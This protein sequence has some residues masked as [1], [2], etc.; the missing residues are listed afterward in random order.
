MKFAQI[1]K[2]QIRRNTIQKQGMSQ[3]LEVETLQ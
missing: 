1:I 3:D 2:K